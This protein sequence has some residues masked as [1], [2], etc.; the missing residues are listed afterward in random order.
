MIGCIVNALTL[1]NSKE[2]ICKSEIFICLL[3]QFSSNI[4]SCKVI[5]TPRNIDLH[6][7]SILLIVLSFQSRHFYNNSCFG[8]TTI[9]LFTASRSSRFGDDNIDRTLQ[10]GGRRAL[11]FFNSCP[12]LTLILKLPFTY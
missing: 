6:R 12:T 1:T 4:C 5:V 8:V 2:T 9:T 3:K 11:I 10:G 7:Y